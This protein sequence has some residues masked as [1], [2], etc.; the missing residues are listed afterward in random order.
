[1]ELKTA[2]K[3]RGW[4]QQELADQAGVDI[5]VVN[6]VEG[7]IRRPGYEA[8]I[9]LARALNLEPEDLFPLGPRRTRRTP[10]QMARAK[11]TV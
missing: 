10:R 3:I 6:R 1:M 8:C 9:R 2:R 5:A 11:A 7:G 4:T